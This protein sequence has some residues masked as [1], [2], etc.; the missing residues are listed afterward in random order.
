MAPKLLE[1]LRKQL[2][3]LLTKRFIQPSCSPY[4]APVL[5]SKK[6]N[7]TLRLCMDYRALN[8]ATIQNKSPI[9][10]ADDLLDQLAGATYFTNLDLSSG[11]HQIEIE[12]ED[13]QKTAFRTRYGSYEWLVMPLG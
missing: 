12:E 1:E 3:E 2:N 8:D 11:Y 13:Q 6:K 9:P 10:R 4:G 5:F 7:G